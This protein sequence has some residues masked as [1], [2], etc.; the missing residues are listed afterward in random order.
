M[1]G[2]KNP[3][4]AGFLYMAQHLLISCQALGSEFTVSSSSPFAETD[5][6]QM[7]QSAVTDE[8]GRRDVSVPGPHGGTVD[9]WTGIL[10][11]RDDGMGTVAKSDFCRLTRGD[12]FRLARRD[13]LT[14]WGS[15]LVGCVALGG[16]CHAC[17]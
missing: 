5:Y 10:R 4:F 15:P 11:V 17:P 3:R 13:F 9:Y 16:S 8:V 12:D 14:G 1:P 6:E 2:T 7:P